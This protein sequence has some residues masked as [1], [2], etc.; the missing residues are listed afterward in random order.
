MYCKQRE[1]GQGS[2]NCTAS[3]GKLGE[4]LETVLQAMGSWARARELYTASDGKLGEGRGTDGKLIEGRGT[5]LQAIGNWAR[6]GGLYCK[7]WE[8]G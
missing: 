5:V 2:G 3:N 6:A 7:Q 4:G 8:A 1:A